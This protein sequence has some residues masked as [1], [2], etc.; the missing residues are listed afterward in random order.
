M[1][2]E[3]PVI[4]AV[5]FEGWITMSVSWSVSGKRRERRFSRRIFALESVLNVIY[6][7]FQ[8]TSLSSR[9]AP[10]SR[11]AAHRFR[12]LSRVPGDELRRGHRLRAG[13]SGRPGT[14]LQRQPAVGTGRAGAL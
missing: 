6:T 8:D 9:P 2:L 12:G 10:R 11:H 7:A 4:R 14:A 3:A 13:Q 1:P 5:P